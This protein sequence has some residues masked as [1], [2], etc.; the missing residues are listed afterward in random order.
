MDVDFNQKG[1]AFI[2]SV[3]EG[4]NRDARSKSH[5]SKGRYAVI[6]KKVVIFFPQLKQILRKYGFEEYNERLRL[7][8]EFQDEFMSISIDNKYLRKGK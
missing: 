6:S 7:G 3:M 5:H 8:I 4:R 2:Y 1:E